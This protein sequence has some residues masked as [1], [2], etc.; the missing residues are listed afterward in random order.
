[1]LIAGDPPANLTITETGVAPDSVPDVVS[2]LLDI[3]AFAQGLAV[4]AEAAWEIIERLRHQK[5]AAFECSITDATR[6]LIL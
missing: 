3:D 6:E 2:V 1:M 5:N 4:T